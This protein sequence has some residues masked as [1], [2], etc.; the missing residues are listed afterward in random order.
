DRP[1]RAAG[2]DCYG[3]FRRSVFSLAAAQQKGG[4]LTMRLDVA[5]VSLE[6]GA[7]C[8]VTDATLH[9]PPGEIVGLI[10]PNG[11]GKT[12][13]LRSVYR[14]LRPVAGRILL[15]EADVWQMSARQSAQHT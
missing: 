7:A 6:I 13:L 1:A 15:N 14:R 9:V 3:R 8:I 11:S 5:A 10:G 12:T 2:G 4:W